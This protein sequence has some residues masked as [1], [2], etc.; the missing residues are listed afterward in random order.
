MPNPTRVVI[1]GA[2][3]AGAA[4]ALTLRE[5]DFD[6]SIALI[7]AEPHSPYERPPLSKAYLRGE[8]GREDARVQV[9]DSWAARGI[10]LRIGVA[11]ARIDRA[12]GRVEL[13]DGEILDY[14]RLVLATGAA[15]RSLSVPGAD[16]D[17][18][19]TL[20]TFEDADTIRTRARE[21]SRV[22]VVGGGWLGSE[23][24][25]SLRQMGIPVVLAVTGELPLS[26]ALGSTIGG[27]YD[28]LHREHGVAVLPRTRITAFEGIGQVRGAR[29]MAGDR[30][31]AD[32]V[33]AAVGAS[34]RLE[35]ALAARLKVSDGVVVNGLLQT[36]DPRILAVG[37]IAQA[38][39]P[40]LGRSLRVEHWGTALSQGTH[41]AGTVLG[42]GDVYADLPY[43][44]SDQYDTGMEFWGDPALPGALVVR[45]DLAARSFTAFWHRD[46]R[47]RAALNMHVHHHEHADHT[48][49]SDHQ[50]TATAAVHA[51]GHVD[52]AV[53]TRLLHSPSPVD[54]RALA[55]PAVPIEQIA[56]EVS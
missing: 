56:G 10:D 18:V 50:E 53:V 20:R 22:L 2:G 27:M 40:D 49:D 8:T 3:Q 47:V 54:V 5:Q 1:V 38:P 15:A 42:K 52:P 28:G 46:G 35:L 33:V 23:I 19:L 25:A 21:V 14:D 34:P 31:E 4:A 51:G 43:F 41:A 26:R 44:F 45:G 11:V 9:E 36:D 37:D 32:L 16:L 12:A 7:G 24:A 13:V 17:G 29:T 39:Y 48:G 6:G 30:I 55:D